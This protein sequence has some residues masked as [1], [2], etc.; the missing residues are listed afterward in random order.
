MAGKTRGFGKKNAAQPA[1]KASTGVMCPARVFSRESGSGGARGVPRLSS[2]LQMPVC[3]C[4]RVRVKHSL[5]TKKLS[6]GWP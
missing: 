3:A 1:S 2:L 6:L 4:T 5:R